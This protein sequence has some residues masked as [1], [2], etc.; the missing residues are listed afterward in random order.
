MLFPP[1]ETVTQFNR[2]DGRARS[3]HDADP[4]ARMLWL[5]VAIDANRATALSHREQ[6]P[7]IAD[8]ERSITRDEDD[9]ARHD[10]EARSG[11][12]EHTVGRAMRAPFGGPRFVAQDVARVKGTRAELGVGP[13]RRTAS[14]GR[15]R[16]G[17]NAGGNRVGR[18][19]P[20]VLA[21]VGGRAFAMAAEGGHAQHNA[22]RADATQSVS[23]AVTALRPSF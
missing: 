21:C 11:R 8:G 16:H 13:E 6:C 22:R 18:I 9:R 1:C 19:E 17:A 2:D 5:G 20:R 15:W 10:G 23:A 3:D 12:D 4:V 7:A 14:R